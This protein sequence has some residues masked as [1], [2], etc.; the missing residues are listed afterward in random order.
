[1][2]RTRWIAAAVF[3]VGVAE[4]RSEA[5]VSARELQGSGYG[6]Y[7]TARVPL[8]GGDRVVALHLLDENL[9][10][11]TSSGL[12]FA[13]QAD[14]G[15][16]R[17][18]ASAGEH[19]AV[20]YP[21]THLRSDSADGP[22][23]L[24]TH[25]WVKVLDRYRGELVRDIELPLPASAAAAADAESMYI[26][27]G[28]SR[29][30]SLRWCGDPRAGGLVRWHATLDGLVTS[31]PVIS[32]DGRVFF[33]T[34]KG[35]VYCIRGADKALLWQSCR[36]ATVS[37]GLHVDESGV[38]VASSDHRL[39]VLDEQTGDAISRYLLPG[40][41]F[42][43]PVVV[44]RTVYQYC[45]GAGMFA[46]DTDTRD[47]MWNLADVT[48]FVARAAEKLVAMDAGGDL[49]FLDNDTGALRG[50]MALPESAMAAENG[51]DAVLYLAMPDGRVMCAKPSGFP[52]LRREQLVDARLGLHK[53]PGPGASGETPSRADAP[54]ADGARGAVPDPLRSGRRSQ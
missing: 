42:D 12:W 3:A 27:G 43:T 21:P 6:E 28:D 1:M 40:P 39:Y 30:Y 31:A 5:I 38:Y 34:D 26:G 10:A 14:T 23:V 47:A 37:G 32:H 19:V 17:W 36:C 50:S 53:P 44:Q 8:V 18:A 46:Y 15:L 35:S 52:Y 16:V 22:V 45:R 48:R 41:L 54:G 13:L 51:R 11:G 20:L 2:T 4:V 29:F 9:Y 49:V 33:A 24:T 25:G 7:W